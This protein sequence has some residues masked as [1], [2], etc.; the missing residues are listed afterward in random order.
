MVG[1]TGMYLRWYL[2]GKGGAPKATPA[3]TAAV[4]AALQV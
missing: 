2:Q 3:A 4:Q 1:G